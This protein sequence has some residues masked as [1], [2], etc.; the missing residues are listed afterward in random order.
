[1]PLNFL[2]SAWREMS[3]SLT[4]MRIM[5]EL[6]ALKPLIN[7]VPDARLLNL[8]VKDAGTLFN[9]LTILA[10]LFTSKMTWYSASIVTRDMY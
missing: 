9:T 8:A 4:D 2:G 7:S 1:M 10:Q 6:M 3:L 5:F